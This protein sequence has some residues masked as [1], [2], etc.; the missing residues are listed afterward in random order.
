MVDQESFSCFADEEN[1]DLEESD[2]IR[3]LQR[4]LKSTQEKTT[5]EEYEEASVFFNFLSAALMDND[6]INMNELGIFFWI[7]FKY[8]A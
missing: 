6:P 8:V 5:R 4:K 3:N 7:F 1:S 2:V